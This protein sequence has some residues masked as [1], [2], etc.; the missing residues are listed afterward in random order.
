MTFRTMTGER[1]TMK[2]TKAMAWAVAVS[3]LGIL[4]APAAPASAQSLIWARQFGSVS[5]DPAAGVAVDA[6]GNSYVVGWTDGALPGQTSSG[7]ADAWVR[8]YDATGTVVWTHQFGAGGFA[9]ALGVAVDASGDVYV[10]GVTDNELPGQINGGGFRDDAF[11]RKYD[12]GGAI[13]WT[14]QFGTAGNDAALGVAVDASGNVYVAGDV[15]GTL[16][17]QIS[18][19][20]YDAFVRTYDPAGGVLW[21]SQFGTSGIDS[22]H[23]VAVDA[24]GNAWAAG[25][26]TGT[27]AG[28]TSAGGDDAFA[29]AY[30]SAG[31]ALWTSQFGTAGSDFANGAAVDASGNASV[32]GFVN[33]TL[34]GQSSSG[35]R[36]AFVL[37]YAAAGTVLW[38]RQF[39]TA[40]DDYAAGVAMD[41]NGNAYVVGGADGTLPG[42]ASAGGFDAFVRAYDSS[43]SAL[44]TYQFG[45]ADRDGASS[46]AVDTAGT[47]S[48]AGVTDGTLPGQT[49]AGARDAFVVR[50]A[51][52]AEAAIQALI[53]DLDAIHASPGIKRSL[54]AKLRNAQR[55]LARNGRIACQ[56]LAAFVNEVRAQSG[57]H[58][59]AA[60]AADL[61]A[62]AESIQRSLGCR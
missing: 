35:G 43:G 32:V 29:R 14:R 11:L 60:D 16:S 30:D 39:G 56:A 13:L 24:S 45:S 28:Q 57:K 5:S 6:S 18:S 31:T 51:G 37:T 21:T 46:V 53:D 62:A 33:G 55:S 2:S 19:G 41:A 10:A 40:G 44:W 58:I 3:L 23:G 1:M 52:S 34:I 36:D 7:G 49:S 22:A 50:I 9:A 12:S 38:T 27:F 26:T 47:L 4:L 20:G 54:E 8:K 25:V 17:G 42:Q 48:V 15:E 59:S 61:I